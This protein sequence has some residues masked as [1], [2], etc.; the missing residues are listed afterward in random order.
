[1]GKH[2]VHIRAHMDTHMY[3][4]LHT[5]DCTTHTD[6]KQVFKKSFQNQEKMHWVTTSN[7]F[8]GGR[9]ASVISILQRWRQARGGFRVI[10]RPSRAT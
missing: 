6:T 5:H 1:M 3:S 7:I 4:G 10:V 8:V 9:D 2:T